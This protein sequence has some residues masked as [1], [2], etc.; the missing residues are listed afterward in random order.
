MSEAWLLLGF[1]A[2]LLCAYLY[3]RFSPKFCDLFVDKELRHEAR[4]IYADLKCNKIVGKI[5]SDFEAFLWEVIGRKI[6]KSNKEMLLIAKQQF[7]KAIKKNPSLEDLKIENPQSSATAIKRLVL[8][9][10][11][12]ENQKPMFYHSN[13]ASSL[14]ILFLFMGNVLKAK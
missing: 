11:Q 12:I 13:T 7:E 9:A 4:N 14:L 8:I 2:F 6:T 3:D 1:L 5:D 10:H